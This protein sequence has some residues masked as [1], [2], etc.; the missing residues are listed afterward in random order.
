MASLRLRLIVIILK[1]CAKNRHMPATKA[2]LQVELRKMME[3]TPWKM[4]LSTMKLHE[5]HT[6]KAALEKVKS[7]QATAT[8][9]IPFVGPGRPKS[10]PIAPAVAEE[11]D[12]DAIKVPE[13][14]APRLKKAPPIRVAKDPEQPIGNPNFKKKEA[15][16]PKKVEIEEPTGKSP[17]SH[18]CNCPSCPTRR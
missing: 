15:P 9:T 10:R 18:I 1:V 16:K 6:A 17:R 8:S 3:G 5:L 12:E 7:E 13:P 2:E 14:P 4:P 11:D